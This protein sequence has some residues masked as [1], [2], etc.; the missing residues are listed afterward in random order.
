MTKVLIGNDVGRSG[1]G[2]AVSV[3]VFEEVFTVHVLLMGFRVDV[4]V[5]DG[6]DSGDPRTGPS[7]LSLVT[8]VKVFQDWVEASGFK[9][10][11]VSLEKARSIRIMETTA[12]KRIQR[13]RD[14]CL[15]ITGTSSIW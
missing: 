11:T 7:S 13:H 10:V 14:R 2:L 4:A 6:T 5:T 15:G 1:T 8:T 9:T 12:N 3:V